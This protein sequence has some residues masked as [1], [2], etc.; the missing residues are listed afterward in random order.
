[1]ARGYLDRPRLTAERF[2]PDPFAAEPGARVYRT[3]DRVRWLASGELEFVGR[4]DQQVKIRGFRVEPGEIEAVLVRRPGVEDAVVVARADGPGGEAP[5]LVAYLVPE[6]GA[7]PSPAELRAALR[8]ELPPYMVPA[9]WVVLDA[10]PLTRTGKVDRRA[11]P[12]PDAASLA[13]ETVRAAPRSDVERAVAEAW[14]AVLGVEE[15]GLDDN[16]FDLGGHSL[17][18]ARL[19]GRLAGRFAREATLVELF[20]YPTVRSL[21]EH[22]ARAEPRDAVPAPSDAEVESRRAA[23]RRRRDLKT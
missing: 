16:F 2:L 17:L 8:A 4:T 6:P 10:F 22:L 11:L 5:R 7:T 18:L 12:A 3:G 19:R 15:V 21:A 13:R 23:M 14:S 20:R 9:A 1:M